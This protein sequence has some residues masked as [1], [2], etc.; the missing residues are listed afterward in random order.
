M[1]ECPSYAAFGVAALF[2]RCT[3]HRC[4]DGRCRVASLQFEISV[5]TTQF[6]WVD[7]TIT[8]GHHDMSHDSDDNDDTKEK[9]TKINIRYA[10]Q[11][12][13]LIT[14]LAAVPEPTAGGMGTM[15]DNTV[16]VWCNELAKG[17]VHSHSPQPFV[18]AGGAGGALQTG[19]F[20]QYNKI[21]HN[22]LCVL[23]NQHDGGQRDHFR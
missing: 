9:L 17:N 15:L 14:T 3:R 10:Q 11:F 23:A 22:Y 12:N 4:G 18:L 20:M 8:R 5:G 7:P 16:I 1:S 21:S 19:R 2:S 13:Y 6:T